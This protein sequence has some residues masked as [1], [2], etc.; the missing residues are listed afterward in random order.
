MFLI[1][2]KGVKVF[3]YLLLKIINNHT[4]YLYFIQYI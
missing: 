1:R 2:K 4:I 3:D